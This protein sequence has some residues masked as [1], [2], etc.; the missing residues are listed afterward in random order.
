M[1]ICESVAKQ[2]NLLNN[3]VSNMRIILHNMRMFATLEGKFFSRF[4]G[5]IKQS[6][7]RLS[8]ALDLIQET[9]ATGNT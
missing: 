6:K 3:L 1:Q 9:M 7:H 2:V 8:Y 4:C 5:T